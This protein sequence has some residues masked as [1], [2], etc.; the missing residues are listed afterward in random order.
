MY[1]PCLTDCKACFGTC[2]RFSHTCGQTHEDASACLLS[3]GDAHD[4]NNESVKHEQITLYSQSAYIVTTKKHGKLSTVSK[5]MRVMFRRSLM[6]PEVWEP[7]SASCFYRYTVQAASIGSRHP[8]YV[9]DAR[10]SYCLRNTQSE[11]A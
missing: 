3:L 7:L 9:S 2:R 5:Q 1:C 6:A 11:M 8:I 4:C 10:R